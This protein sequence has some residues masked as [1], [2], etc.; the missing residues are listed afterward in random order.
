MDLDASNNNL[1][2]STYIPPT[3]SELIDIFSNYLNYTDDD[4]I[5]EFDRENLKKNILKEK[6]II[7]EENYQNGVISLLI[8]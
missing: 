3:T 8:K 4:H 1:T 5:Y 7:L 6:F 2:E